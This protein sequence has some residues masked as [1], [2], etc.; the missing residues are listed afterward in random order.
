MNEERYRKLMAVA[1]TRQP[2]LTAL[3]EKVHKPHNLSAV[4]RSCDAVGVL[5]A[6]AVWEAE[7][8][9]L[10]NPTS[11]GARKWV[12]LME[13]NS[14]A[15]AV[16]YLSAEG[17]V[18]V[19]AHPAENAKDFREID[20]CEKTAILLGAELEGLTEEALQLADHIV[21]IP[22][23]GMVQSLNVSVAAAIILYEAQRQRLDAG[24]YDTP[25]LGEV[26][27]EKLVFEWSYPRVARRLAATGQPYPAL[28]EG[29]EII[30]PA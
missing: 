27:L 18:I 5:Q 8:V 26:A 25:Q 13:H 12:D 10:H 22:Q 4:L 21:T 30:K 1:R 20:Y 16:E 29:G 17:F 28:T 2:N 23:Q 24:L 15:E 3:M 9:E 19:A 14:I 11:A 7:E 6:H